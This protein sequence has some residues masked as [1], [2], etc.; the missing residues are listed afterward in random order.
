MADKQNNSNDLP[1]VT[2]TS[3]PMKW[4]TDAAN[5]KNLPSKGYK[6]GYSAA[7]IKRQRQVIF[8]KAYAECGVSYIACE[9]AGVNPATRINWVKKDP[10]FAEQF[11]QAV[12]NY[13]DKLEYEIHDRA[14]N[15]V[16]VPIIGRKQVELGKDVMG[17]P[18]FGPEDAIIGTKKQKSDLLL[19]FHAKKVNPEYREKYE[20]PKEDRHSG[21]DSPMARITVRLEMI[22]NRAQHGISA[23]QVNVI[24]EYTETQEDVIDLLPESTLL[25]EKAESLG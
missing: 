7:A 11:K 4:S 15:G 14:V 18:V 17:N 24:P 3:K 13:R 16:D 6:P 10:W 12:E 9:A 19:M 5:G 25:P 8:L 22:A 1:D 21:A 20:A 2:D 23:P